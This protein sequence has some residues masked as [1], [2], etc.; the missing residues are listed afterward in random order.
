LPWDSSSSG[1]WTTFWGKKPINPDDEPSGPVQPED[2]DDDDSDDDGQDDSNN[3]GTN[4]IAPYP[5]SSMDVN[6]VIK[7]A[8]T[9][10]KEQGQCGSCWAF[11]VHGLIE[12]YLLIKGRGKMD[13]SEQQL[14]DCERVSF[15]CN[16]GYM[17]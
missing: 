12:S 17:H 11:G 8:T 6:W 10:V 5:A 14:V 4:P 15:G 7:G 9:H 2:L 13:L 16:G 3:P 1:W